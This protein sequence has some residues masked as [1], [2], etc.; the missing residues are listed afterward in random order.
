MHITSTW[1]YIINAP[2][3][4]KNI[5]FQFVKWCILR[6][7]PATLLL[8]SISKQGMAIQ[9]IHTGIIWPVRYSTKDMT[10]YVYKL[11]VE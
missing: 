7:K 5:I 2:G 9:S 3:A 8:V 11:S 4:T 10:V 1:L 6:K